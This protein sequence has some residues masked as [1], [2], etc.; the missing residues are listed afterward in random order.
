MLRDQIARFFDRPDP[1]AF[2]SLALA[3]FTH[4]YRNVEAYQRLC[5]ARGRRPGCIHTWQEIPVVP[6]AAFKTVPLAA[7]PTRI[8]FRSSGTTRGSRHRSVHFQ[9]FPN[10]Y[11]KVIDLSFPGPCLPAPAPVP[12]LSLVPALRQAPDSSLSFMVDHILNRFGDL[13]SETAFGLR[14]VRCD[15]ATAWVE[16]AEERGQPV[17]ILATAFAL[18]Q[19]LDHLGGARRTLRLP[20]G[21][22]LFETGGFKGRSRESTRA[23]LL[24]VVEKT[25]GLPS[26][27]V[28]REYGM[29]ELSSQFYTHVLAGDDE[30][31]FYAPPWTRVRILDP[32]TLEEAVEGSPGLITVLD[33]ANLGSALHVMTEDLGVAEGKGFRLLG[34]AAGADL[35][36]CSLTVEE[37]AR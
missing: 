6:A 24:E 10:L 29:T 28:V 30:D 22:T 26:H 19:W 16:A 20:Q 36:G 27:R 25:L 4:Q 2:D 5:N 21:S 18:L 14:G 11:R 1:E 23:E 7:G 3:A 12:I 34:R 37:L 35:R 17:L 32:E 33:L 15:E 13:T 8:T 9:P 31:L